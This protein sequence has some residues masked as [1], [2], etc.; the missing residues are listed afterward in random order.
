MAKIC[1]PHYKNGDFASL[2][3]ALK[4]LERE[5][6]SISRYALCEIVQYNTCYRNHLRR[7]GVEDLIMRLIEEA[8]KLKEEK[9]LLHRLREWVNEEKLANYDIQCYNIK[10]KVTILGHTFNG[11]KDIVNHVEMSGCEGYDGLHCWSKSEPNVYDDVHIGKIYDSYPIFDSSDLSD[12]RTYQNYIFSHEPITQEDMNSVYNR[13]S[14][15]SNFCM[16][17]EDIKDEVILPILYYEGDGKYMLLATAK[18]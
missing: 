18:E 2:S 9:V 1:F 8:P 13:T 16:V 6:Y 15:A 12:N 7:Y 5:T 4:F 10:D 14:H 11:L 17:N 3:D